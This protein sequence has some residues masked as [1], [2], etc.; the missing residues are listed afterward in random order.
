M[1]VRFATFR[2]IWIFLAFAGTIILWGMGDLDAPWWLRIVGGLATMIVCMTLIDFVLK[3]F[4]G[5][6]H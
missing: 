6:R 2:N 4:W 5:Y 3:K 1:R